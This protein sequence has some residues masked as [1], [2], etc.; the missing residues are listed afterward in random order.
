[1]AKEMPPKNFPIDDEGNKICAKCNSKAGCTRPVMDQHNSNLRSE[2][3]EVD[4]LHSFENMTAWIENAQ[5]NQRCIWGVHKAITKE[6]SIQFNDWFKRPG[7][8]GFQPYDSKFVISIVRDLLQD[9]YE[10]SYKNDKEK[11]GSGQKL[12]K[13]QKNDLLYQI[14]GVERAYMDMDGAEVFHFNVDCE[15]DTTRCNDRREFDGNNHQHPYELEGTEI[16]KET[17]A[18]VA[19]LRKQCVDL[20][21]DPKTGPQRDLDKTTKILK[22]RIEEHKDKKALAVV[23]KKKNEGRSDVIKENKGTV[24]VVAGDQ[25]SKHM[26]NACSA[27]DIAKILSLINRGAN[28]NVETPRG[29]R[30]LLVVIV[31][32]GNPDQISKVVKGGAYINACNRIGLTALMLA[33]RLRDTRLVHLL[34]QQGADEVTSEGRYGQGR[35]ALHYCALHSAEDEAQAL[36]DYT[37]EGEGEDVMRLMRF[38]DFQDKNG[39]SPLMVAARNRNG[40]MCYNLLKMGADPKVMN[41]QKRNAA[42]IAREYSYGALADFL[43]SKITS[44]VASIETFSDLQFEKM[45]RFGGLKLMELIQQYCNKILKL[46]QGRNNVTILMCPSRIQEFADMYGDHEKHQLVNR[47]FFFILMQ[48]PNNADTTAM[49]DAMK[50]IVQDIVKVVREGN[51]YPSAEALE[52][53]L[54]W[55]ALMCAVAMNDSRSMRL[56]CH[57]G[58]DPNYQNRHGMTA[59]MLAAQLNN[60][61]GICE[62]LLLGSDINVVDNEGYN[63]YAYAVSLPYAKPLQRSA[64]NVLTDGDNEATKRYTADEVLK[65]AVTLTPVEI[66]VRVKA[67][68]KKCTAVEIKREMDRLK[69][70]EKNGLSKVKTDDDVHHNVASSHWRIDPEASLTLFGEDCYGDTD[71]KISVLD[72]VT[73]MREH[74]KQKAKGEK[75]R[76]P[77]CTLAIPCKH[78]KKEAQAREYARKK[79]REDLAAIEKKK[80]KK[81]KDD[82]DAD[83]EEEESDRHTYKE[84][85]NA[86]YDK[87]DGNDVSENENLRMQL[88]IEKERAQILADRLEK[89]ENETDGLNHLP[90]RTPVKVKLRRQLHAEQEKSKELANKLEVKKNE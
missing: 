47:Y 76:C 37:R 53:P 41:S 70:L 83:E 27:N 13:K 7:N 3:F 79:E 17:Y 33:C 50:Q 23:S 15:R 39:D 24:K 69:I 5:K 26:G 25:L 46:L 60:I 66:K 35:T 77:I 42:Y 45:Q 29:M 68:L 4:Q 55:T 9:L 54:P 51:V 82:E 73:K 71:K 32:N 44:G 21:L 40:L 19:D 63:A 16:D 84:R 64:S 8:D 67:N 52:K 58:A 34:L 56:I 10:K 65:M 14:N 59:L 49:I 12:T 20:G 30:P 38:V 80:A 22:K 75:P 62:L 36:Y 2:L 43:D 31:N 81:K 1:M 78:F 90:P 85:S 74:E 72:A 18:E 88:E 61:E 48:Q 11:K 89:E 87:E 28:A 6:E 57:E 86:L